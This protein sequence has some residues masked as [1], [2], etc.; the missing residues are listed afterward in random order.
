MFGISWYN[1]SAQPL[2]SVYFL[3]LETLAFILFYMFNKTK[4]FPME[5]ASVPPEVQYTYPWLG[6]T[7]VQHLNQTLDTT[8]WIY[9]ENL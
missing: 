9:K 6:F 2:S 3:V 1:S 7:R 5:S 4:S 8:P